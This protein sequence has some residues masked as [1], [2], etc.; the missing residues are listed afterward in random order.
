MV[1]TFQLWIDGI[2]Y[3]EGGLKID[4][5]RMTLWTNHIAWI[6]NPGLKILSACSKKIT[7]FNVIDDTACHHFFIKQ[8][9]QL[10]QNCVFIK[11]FLSKYRWNYRQQFW[12]DSLGIRFWKF[13]KIFENAWVASICLGVWFSKSPRVLSFLSWSISYIK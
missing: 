10:R 2:I 11:D 13:C 5:C 4:A 9:I 1:D 12:F 8:W 7:V 6:S 3:A